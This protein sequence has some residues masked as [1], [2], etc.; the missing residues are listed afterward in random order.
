MG[1]IWDMVLMPGPL[2]GPFTES[3]YPQFGQ[4]SSTPPPVTCCS[5]L[6][7]G[8][9]DRETTSWLSRVASHSASLGDRPL[10][11]SSGMSPVDWLVA[12]VSERNMLYAVCGRERMGQLSCQLCVGRREVSPVSQHP[13]GAS[14]RQT[15]PSPAHSP[16]HH[17]SFPPG[18]WLASQR[19][20]DCNPP[21]PLPG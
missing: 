16:F 18:P 9:P 20:P 15:D 5:P 3:L 6:S 10:P 17:C 8:D 7:H 13:G 19:F 1:E 11:P 4:E 14:L 12:H 2:E 21:A